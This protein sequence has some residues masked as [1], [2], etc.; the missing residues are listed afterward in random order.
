[1]EN[2]DDTIADYLS[3]GDPKSCCKKLENLLSHGNLSDESLEPMEAKS[4][5]K[6]KLHPFHYL[7]LNAYTTSASAYK[8]RASDFLALNYE[9][10][11]HKLEAFNMYKT[12]SAYSLLLAGVANHLFTFESALVTTVANFWINAGE[13]MLNLARSSLWDSFLKGGPLHLELSYF[14]TFKCNDCRFADTLEPNSVSPDQNM[15]LEEIKSQLYNCI[16]NITPKVWGILASESSFLKLIQNPID[17][18]W[19]ASPVTSRIPDTESQLANSD[20]KKGSSQLEAEECND[21][22]RM[23]LILLSIHCLRYGALLS[24]I[25]YGLS[26]EMNY[27]RTL[28]C[29]KEPV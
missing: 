14:L 2:F 8:V 20:V 13:S 3:C 15:Q 19:L 29:L 4:P 7:S 9:V 25:C 12:S 18:S 5:Q 16:A 26:V 1:M 17:L 10:E 28:E 11:R 27:H 22:V 6:V 21:Q 24:S 23:N